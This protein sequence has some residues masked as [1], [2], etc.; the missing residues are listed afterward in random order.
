MWY[1]KSWLPKS[2]LQVRVLQSPGEISGVIT[3]HRG[4]NGPFSANISHKN[5]S[6]NLGNKFT[7]GGA[8]F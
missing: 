8:K 6:F 1:P 7:K 2:R 3:V 5:A 4:E